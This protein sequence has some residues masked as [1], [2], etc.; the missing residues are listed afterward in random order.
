MNTENQEMEPAQ[1]EANKIAQEEANTLKITN[2]IIRQLND[3]GKWGKFLAILGFVMM[4]LMVV[5]GFVLSITLAFI[6][7]PMADMFPFPPIVIGLFYLLIATL[8]F[9]PILYLYRFSTGIK[10]ALL[11]KNQD[12]LTRAFFNLKSLYRFIGILM[13]VFLALYPI[14]IVVMIFVGL[15]SGFSQSTGLPA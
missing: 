1:P 14:I 6:P 9:L 12:Q 3:A 11:L 13:I 7:M 10:Q 15:F 2:E 4:G 8:Y 5:F